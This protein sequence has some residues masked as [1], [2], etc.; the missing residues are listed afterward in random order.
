M[1]KGSIVATVIAKESY[2]H[3][4][5][6]LVDLPQAHFSLPAPSPAS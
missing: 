4:Q 6:S 2:R 3:A 5:A 1:A